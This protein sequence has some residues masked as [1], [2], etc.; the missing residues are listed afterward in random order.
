M[1][2]STIKIVSRATFGKVCR[3]H[4]TFVHVVLEVFRLGGG[5]DLADL[6]PS[7]NML[8]VLTG[9]GRKMIK[10]RQKLDL[11]LDE[12]INEHIEELNVSDKRNCEAGEDDLTHAL[13]RL[14]DSGDLQIPLGYGNI[15][16]IIFDMFAGGTD[17]SATVVDW[18]MA[19]M[20]RNPHVMAKAKNEIRQALKGKKTIEEDDIKGLQYLGL[21]IKETLRL[22]PPG[23]LLIPRECR[24][25][26][27]L[28]GYKIPVGTKV[29]IN[30]WAIARDPEIWDDAYSFVPERFENNSIDFSG[31][32]FE[33]LPFGSGRRMCPGSSFGL[34]N[35]E[36]PLA[37]LL[38]HFDW[39]L[40]DGI[41]FKDLDMTE[42]SGLSASRKNHLYLVPIP[43]D[44]VPG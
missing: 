43:Y 36:L 33:Y 19:E 26:C 35:V 44:P 40:P 1:L 14:K 20:M 23:P 27:E 31:R 18:A 22:H 16:A 13:L 28:D 37:L 6:F 2:S 4:A 17:V 9:T 12:V 5:F 11:I 38:F 3:D 8:H 24:E 34:A 41:H 21:I 39:K 32:Y 7:Y 30:A 42:T 10:L 15:K 29:F 25:E